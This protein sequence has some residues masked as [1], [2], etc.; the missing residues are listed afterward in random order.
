M[1]RQGAT[2]VEQKTEFFAR[3]KHDRD[4][5]ELDPYRNTRV[6][7]TRE[8]AGTE[9]LLHVGNGGV[10]EDDTTQV[11]RIVAVDVFIDRLPSSNFPPSVTARRGDALVLDEPDDSYEMVLEALLY[12]HL[13]GARAMD[14]I[15]NI[16]RAIAEAGRVPR[17]GG[18]PVVAESCVPP[19]FYRF[20]RLAVRPLALMARTRLL[21]GYPAVLQIPFALC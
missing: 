10:F 7:L 13:V 3:D 9:L 19:W 17:P 2:S 21:G 11:E 5:A 8:V 12:H 4:P 14:S 1:G 16:R 20:E 18:H 15:A 6:A